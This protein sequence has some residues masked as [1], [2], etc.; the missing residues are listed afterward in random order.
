MATGI[1]VH[2]TEHFMV[3]IFPAWAYYVRKSQIGKSIVG[4]SKGGNA[5]E[6]ID[7]KY[8]LF[9]LGEDLRQHLLALSDSRFPMKQPR[10]RVIV[11]TL[12]MEN[13]EGKVVNREEQDA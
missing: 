10:A 6:D 2:F 8:R 11:E 1:N 4:L 7:E 5:M 3:A 9:Q 12:I 13:G